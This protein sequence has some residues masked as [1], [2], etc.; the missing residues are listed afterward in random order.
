MTSLEPLKQA[1]YG[2]LSANADDFFAVAELRRW[3]AK[4]K[5]NVSPGMVRSAL[6]RLHLRRLV[7]HET[8]RKW[9]KSTIEGREWTCYT[10]RPAIQRAKRQDRR[11]HFKAQKKV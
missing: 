11:L 1:L 8:A 10:N 2:Y 9:R 3:L 5:F 6:Q 4:Q 7:A